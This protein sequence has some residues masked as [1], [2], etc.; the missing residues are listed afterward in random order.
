V[1]NT[2]SY[3]LLGRR[4][5]ACIG[6]D[7][8]GCGIFLGWQWSA[9]DRLEKQ[10]R[11]GSLHTQT[12]YNPIGWVDRVNHPDG[13]S[14]ELFARDVKGRVRRHTDEEGVIAQVEFDGWGRKTQELLPGQGPRAFAYTFG[15]ISAFF[16][17]VERHTTIE[18]DTGIW[19]TLYDYAGRVVQQNRPDFTAVVSTYEGSRLHRMQE[20]ISNPSFN[21]LAETVYQYNS[22]GQLESRTGPFNAASG[23]D[24]VFQYTWSPEGRRESVTGPNDETVYT[25]S[26]GVLTLE[27]VTGVTNKV[28][29]YETDYPRLAGVQTGTTAPYRTKTFQWERGLWLAQEEATDGVS[30]RVNVFSN[31]DAYGTSR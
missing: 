11:G 10:T 31:R 19:T 23:S 2:Y 28:Y 1:A 21:P 18:P 27:Q 15:A 5:G 17:R 8:A 12:I 13:V 26:Q 25:W 9:G 4:V 14:S 6:K 22:D 16:G 24:Y 7:A 3:D 30:T 20:G 29:T